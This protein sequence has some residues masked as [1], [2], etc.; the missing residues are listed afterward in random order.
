M[1]D[2]HP[3]AFISKALFAKQQALS[4]YEKELLA[5][6]MAVKQWHY[7]LIPN[8][9]VIRTDQRSLKHL[10]TQKV[11]TLL[12]HKWLAK[13]MGYDYTIEYKQERE[14]VAADALSRIQG[15][16]LFTTAVSQVEPLLLDEII[17][18]QQ[19]DEQLQTMAQKIQG[20]EQL[21]RVQSLGVT[22]TVQRIKG[23]FYWK[24]VAK[25]AR[26]LIRECDVC[27]WAKHKNVAS[28]GL[29]QPLSVPDNSF[30]DISMDF[31]GGLPKV[32]G[33]DTIL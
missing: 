27:K 18:S 3:I 28:P 30:T 23:M 1:Q 29:L 10:L 7:Y 25:L 4:V 21:P 14:N 22:A 15:A 12:Q 24:G 2:K 17:T 16:S 6:L 11:T 5:I 32:K 20:G 31:I 9:F 33:R 8:H 19:E 13:L 26:Q